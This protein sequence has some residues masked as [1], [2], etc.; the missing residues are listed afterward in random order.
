SILQLDK[1]DFIDFNPLQGHET[2]SKLLS[3]LG[4]GRIEYVKYEEENKAVLKYFNSPVKETDNNLF[5]F[6]LKGLIVSVMS[7]M[8]GTEIEVTETK[9]TRDN[10]DYCEFL[11]YFK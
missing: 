3:F 9:C 8:F 2:I 1:E 11:I 5:C 10:G 4:L 6:F 7:N